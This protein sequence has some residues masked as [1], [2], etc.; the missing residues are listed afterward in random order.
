MLILGTAKAERVQIEKVLDYVMEQYFFISHRHWVE[1]GLSAS[2]QTL[3]ITMEE[4]EE[5]PWLTTRLHWEWLDRTGGEGQTFAQH[6]LLTKNKRL[7]LRSVLER[8]AGTHNGFYQVVSIANEEEMILADLFTGKL[9]PVRVEPEE[10]ALPWS[11]LMTRLYPLPN[12]HWLIVQN[13]CILAPA[14]ARSLR[15]WWRRLQADRFTAAYPP[16]ADEESY[17]AYLKASGLS[18]AYKAVHAADGELFEQ[19]AEQI[20]SLMTLYQEDRAGLQEELDKLDPEQKWLFYQSLQHLLWF[21]AVESGEGPPV[22]ECEFS[23]GGQ[24]AEFAWTEKIAEVFRNAI[25]HEESLGGSAETGL[26]G[27]EAFDEMAVLLDQ[28]VTSGIASPQLKEIF[29]KLKDGSDLSQFEARLLE[30]ELANMEK[31]A[32]ELP[33]DAVLFDSADGVEIELPWFDAT[34]GLFRNEVLQDK[35]DATIEKYDDAISA[36]KAYLSMRGH[37]IHHWGDITEEHIAEFI[38]WW[39]ICMDVSSTRT[40]AARLV[41]AMGRLLRWLD[42]A[43]WVK[44]WRACKPL[45]DEWKTTLPHCFL[46]RERAEKCFGNAL[47]LEEKWE[48]WDGSFQLLERTGQNQWRVLDCDK[49]KKFTVGVPAELDSVLQAGLILSGLLRRSKKEWRLI[50]VYYVHPKQALKYLW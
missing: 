6:L 10:L 49:H 16:L 29:L 2:L 36:F 12:G 21:S 34:F 24:R 26:E 31:M 20:S 32:E 45:L 43:E 46:V 39:Y 5:E 33:D 47:L 15:E 40:G 1:Q 23:I 13:P 22:L 14:Y 25:F 7:P 11:I 44:L 35:A 3:E 27:R 42:K 9:Y 37:E 8:L 17:A 30:R 4:A 18:L 19:D 38:C 48:D 50:G 28:L 41:S